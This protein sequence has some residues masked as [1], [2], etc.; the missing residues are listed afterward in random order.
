MQPIYMLQGVDLRLSNAESGSRATTISKLTIPPVE[1]VTASH[2]PGGGVTSVDYALPRTKPFEPA[3]KVNGL[4]VELIGK[5]GVKEVWTFAKAFRD[6]TN[7][8]DVAYRGT[9]EGVLTQWEPDESDP[10]EFQGCN[11]V[12]KEVTHFDISF[13]GKE[14]IYI[15]ADEL[16]IRLNGISRTVGYRGALGV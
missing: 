10:E 3:A 15:D 12:F 1:F 7:G 6:K 4:D 2:S 9:I 8:Q 5:L 14:L 16:E 13:N 11:H